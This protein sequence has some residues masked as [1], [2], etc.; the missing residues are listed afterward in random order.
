[1]SVSFVHWAGSALLQAEGLVH[2]PS[3]FNS[4]CQNG[5]EEAEQDTW[6]TAEEEEAEIEN[7]SAGLK[8]GDTEVFKMN[9]YEI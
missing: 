1:M 5:E 2:L 4:G 9:E 6:F 3:V 7:L 8:T